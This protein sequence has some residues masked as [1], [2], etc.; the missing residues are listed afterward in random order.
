ML[1][2]SETT[3]FGAPK[4]QEPC[5][6]CVGRYN[7]RSFDRAIGMKKSFRNVVTKATWHQFEQIGDPDDM[8]DID[9]IQ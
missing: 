7:Q 9:E 1:P 5:A 2:I 8:I 6:Q 4:F 3:S